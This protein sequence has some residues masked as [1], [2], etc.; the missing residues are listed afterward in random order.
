MMAI[1]G[2]VMS[3]SWMSAIPLWLGLEDIPAGL[4]VID[5]ARAVAAFHACLVALCFAL[6]ADVERSA[7][8]IQM[9]GTD[10]VLEGLEFTGTCLRAGMPG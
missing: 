5:L 8:L 1:V 6:A 2:V 3:T 10:L 7:A 4:I 9:L